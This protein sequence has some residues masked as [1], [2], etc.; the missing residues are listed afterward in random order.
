MTS[1]WRNLQYV[2]WLVSDTSK[3]LA[4]TLFRFAVPLIALFVTDDPAQAGIIGG[5][6]VAVSVSLT[7]FGGVLADR[8]RRITL[9]VLG[10]SIGVALS[11][12]FTLLALGDSLTFGTLLALQVLLAARAGLFDPS[13]EAA[14]KDLVAAD[15]MG[16]AQAANQARDA[17]L[18]LAGGPI[19]GA[20]LVVGGWLVGAVMAV[21][22]LVSTIAAALIPRLRAAEKADTAT[23]TDEVESSAAAEPAAAAS[24]GGPK[25][26]ALREIRE[27]FTWLFSRPDLRGVLLITTVINLGINTVMTTIVYSLQQDGQSPTTIG[28]FSAG[29]GVMMLAGA[30]MATPVVSRIGAGKLMI[31]G[32][33]LLTIGAAAT[34][35]IR[36]P[37]GIVLVMALPSLLLAPLNAGLGG[38]FMVATP[39]EVIGRAASA[40][41]VFGMGA[42]PLAPLIAGFGLSY[43]GRAGTITIGV[44]LC[45]IA[46]AMAL[47]N[48]PLRSLP[49]EA[50]WTAHAA[51]FTN[52][53]A[54]ASVR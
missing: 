54:P 30:L 14:L 44:V 21:C 4:A 40:S 13:G 25:P 22:Q 28:W 2:S 48:R 50:G 20:L 38:Y 52:A 26:N 47:T 16:R 7:M 41:A 12:A 43:L 3:G 45:V 10:A 5:V 49:A 39:S 51:Q 33:V 19:G 6:G 53:G 42:M 23:D 29:L 11:I 17:A 35:L 15:T 46:A 18:Q 24:A 34:I 9:M 32:L 1:L 31:A 27:G 37:W 36:D 8:H